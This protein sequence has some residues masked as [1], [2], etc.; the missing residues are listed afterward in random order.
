[1]TQDFFSYD[2]LALLQG[3]LDLARTK[4]ISDAE[5]MALACLDANNLPSVR[6]V[7]LRVLDENGLVFFTN[8]E[9]RKGQGLIKHRCAEVCFHWKSIARQVR[10]LGM[11]EEASD[12][13][14]DR[15][16]AARHR[17]SQI[18][19]WASDQSRSMNSY[20]TLLDRV[21]HFEEKF[22]EQ[23][24][25]PRPP[26]WGGFRLTPTQIEFW[27]DKEFRLHKRWIYTR[28]TPQHKWQT[29]WLYP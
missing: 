9:S 5:A 28:E 20:Q 10:V 17:G 7:L 3:W 27:E 8:R 22:K 26:H 14:S 21:E 4:E 2:P 24:A 6:I 19:A 1:M 15:Y 23:S 18:G 11:V 16:F 29:S 25:I 13:E 12:E